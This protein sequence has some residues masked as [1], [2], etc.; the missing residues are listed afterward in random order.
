MSFVESTTATRLR[1][2]KYW[3]KTLGGDKVS[4]RKQI[5]YGRHDT[6]R[7][8]RSSWCIQLWSQAILNFA[9]IECYHLLMIY[10]LL[11]I[12]VAGKILAHENKIYLI[13]MQG[14]SSRSKAFYYL[15]SK[16]QCVCG[17]MSEPSRMNCCHFCWRKK[18]PLSDI[19]VRL[20][21]KY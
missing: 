2:D 8:F 14:Q 11:M 13:N 21:Y 17:W 15:Q 9:S 20:S 18:F 19:F 1:V 4:D 10:I 5:V 3:A 7:H 6:L 12:L 16:I